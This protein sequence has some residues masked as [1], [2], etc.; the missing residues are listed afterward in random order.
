MIEQ[1]FCHSQSLEFLYMGEKKVYSGRGFK[2]KKW[3][4]ES[5]LQGDMAPKEEV[6]THFA[7]V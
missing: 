5:V 1:I 7:D 2:Y 6:L 3:S 4:R